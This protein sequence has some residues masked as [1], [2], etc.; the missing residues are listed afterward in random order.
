MKY[1][2]STEGEST[3]TINGVDYLTKPGDAF[4]CSPGDIH[5]LWNETREIQAGRF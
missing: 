1:R 2:S 3:I 5:N 4:V